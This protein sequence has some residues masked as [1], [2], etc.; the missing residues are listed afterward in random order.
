MTGSRGGGGGDGKCVGL[1]M[2]YKIEMMKKGEEIRG[3]TREYAD[4]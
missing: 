4:G 1:W 2:E 3:E